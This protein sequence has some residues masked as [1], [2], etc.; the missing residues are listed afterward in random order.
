MYL[1]ILKKDL[2]RKKTMNVILLVFVILAATFIAASANNLITV[3]G[4]LDNFF[5]KA[6]VPDYWILVSRQD[7]VEKCRKLAEE[8]GWGCHVSRMFSIAPENVTVQ[9]EKLDYSNQLLLAAPGGVKYFDKNN[10]EIIR[11]NDGEIYV[12]YAI[13]QSTGNDFCEG[14]KILVRQGDIE[15]EFTV[16]GYDKDAVFPGQMIGATRFLISE[17]DMAIFDN[18]DALEFC[19]VEIYTRD[20]DS[21]EKI[22]NMEINATFLINRSG[23]GISYMTDMLISAILLVVSVC[24]IF[25]S[26]VILR[27]IIM[28]TITEEYREIG[29]MKALGIKDGGI[30]KLY[31][32]K[33]FAIA[34]SGSA[35]GLALSFPFGKMM[36]EEVS[37][38]IIISGEDN[39]LINIGAVALAGALVVA[40]SYFCTHKICSFSP[41]DAIRNGETGERFQK[42]SILRLG[43]SRLA[44]VPFMALNDIFSGMKSYI[45]MMIIFLLGTL[46]IILPVNAINTLRSDSLITL[47]NMTK[48]D[49][50]IST[51]LFLGPNEDVE[52]NIYRQFSEIE[53]MFAENSI[54]ADVFQEVLFRSNLS[55]GDKRATNLSVKGCGSVTADMYSY[56]EGTAPQNGHEIALAYIT[57]NRIGAGIG[58]DI[59]V[60]TGRITETYT[61]TA[62]YQCMNNMGESMRFHQDAALD[63]AD[64]MGAFGIQINYKDTPDRKELDR[65][66]E[67][68]AQLY[69]NAEICTSGEYLDIMIGDF[70][71]EIDSV[72][73]LILAII[74]SINILV[75]MLMVKSFITREK[76]GIALL[77][78]LGFRNHSL[79]LIQTLRISIVL[80]VSVTVGAL[81]SP[82]MCDL[83]ITPVFRMMGAYDIAFEIRGIEVYL[84]F[85]FI[86]LAAT[87]LAAFVSAQG[88]RSI[89]T[90]EVSGME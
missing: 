67:L 28:F 14:G 41:M 75:A 83:I 42:K 57:A 69:P 90:S 59:E 29:V 64:V 87:A 79:V 2:K 84:L 56:M 40:F 80:L 68:L 44:V 65:R 86:M 48:S 16:K 71:R 31:L 76:K 43:K 9:G 60:K 23:I 89:P 13:F 39:F 36:M 22:M 7:E 10:E 34:V 4:A 66:K 8:N 47:F 25:I 51:P 78:A 74:L 24:L 54:D 77:K 73:I 32:A 46:L 88:L 12:P 72:K 21:N 27:F 11:I 52:A 38:K 6:G 45:S 63:Y 85:P 15:K 19:S 55:R 62:I 26:I 20:E 35:A 33:Y 49:H 30:R 37:K 50:I 61:V 53:E 18:E 58:D 5:D 82:A 3:T 17:K 81:I 1:T 70:A